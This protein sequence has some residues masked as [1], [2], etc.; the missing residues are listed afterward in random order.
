VRKSSVAALCAALL[1]SGL[2]V[3]AAAA[4]AAPATAA[5]QSV[6][7]R[8]GFRGTLVSADLLYSLD[9]RADAAAELAAAGFDGSVARHGVDAYRLVYRT[10]DPAGRPT[11]ASGLLALPRGRQGALHAVSFTHGTGVHREDAP[12]MRRQDFVSAAT[13]AYAA[14]GF[15]GVAPDYL[16]M[17][18]G[19]GP[20]PW[21]DVPSETTA[22]LDMLR[23]ARAFAPRA[24]HPLRRDVLVTGFS[25]G[26]SAALGLARALQAGEDPWFRAGALAPVSG[27]YDFAGTTL[28]SLSD[29]GRVA[30]EYGAV[31]AAY[32][33]VAAQRLHGGVYA[34][35]AQ[36]FRQP[37]AGTVEALFDGTHTGPEMMAGLPGSIG[38]LLTEE[39][40]R[41]LTD[42]AGALAAALGP[43]SSVC[44]GWT[45][46]M[47]A[48]LYQAT[49][50][51][52]AVTENTAWCRERLLAGGADVPV[53]DLGAVDFQGSRHLGSGVAATAAT[54]DWFRALT[55]RAG[56]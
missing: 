39:G 26:A 1:V 53:V 25:Q 35:P 42:P 7:H 6:P 34:A 28:A 22:S 10:V 11:T 56:A 2:P 31:Y 54:I 16:G 20:H 29:P 46:R 50:D 27:A 5:Q 23:A 36:V 52:Q 24:G 51:E 43:A 18:L 13:I 17:G 40:R 15:A 47:P 38:E 21:M 49:G 37:Y 55:A 32:A 48:R 41:L 3:A 44:T 14:A 19:P 8:D 30:P 33:L 4:P 9:G 12:S 45:P